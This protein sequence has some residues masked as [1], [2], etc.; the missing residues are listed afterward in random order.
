MPRPKTDQEIQVGWGDLQWKFMNWFNTNTAAID[1]CYWP[2]ADWDAFDQ[3][4]AKDFPQKEHQEAF[5]VWSDE[6]LDRHT[7][8]MTYKMEAKEFIAQVMATNFTNNQ[9][10]SELLKTIALYN[11]PWVPIGT[12]Q[13]E[14]VKSYYAF[15]PS[16]DFLK[17]ERVEHGPDVV[18]KYMLTMKAKPKT[19]A[20]SG[21]TSGL[22]PAS[23]SSNVFN[24]STGST[25]VGESAY[26]RARSST[27]SNASPAKENP[28]KA[29]DK[30]EYFV[31]AQIG[32][33]HVYGADYI[34]AV[35]GNMKRIN[36]GPWWSNGFAVVVELNNKGGHGAVYIVYNHAPLKTKETFPEYAGPSEGDETAFEGAA[37]YHE[38]GKVHPSVK[39]KFKVARIADSIVRLGN[40]QNN[41]QFN[42]PTSNYYTQFS[43]TKIVTDK[44]GK[45]SILHAKDPPKP[46]S[47]AGSPTPKPPLNT[48]SPAQRRPPNTGSPT[49]RQPPPTESPTRRG[50][51][52]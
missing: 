46:P 32:T 28:E 23:P 36:Q 44:N 48:G 29:P 19:S 14:G 40:L 41:F 4:V 35:P 10:V 6:W 12:N 51:G 49:R 16:V 39:T 42:V 47:N 1:R 33:L 20:A 3:L 52:W 26:P 30:D 22:T 11:M 31:F 17:P 2:G 43:T 50:F 13:F 38:P 24:P 15:K 7:Q 8:R 34:P 21:T 9:A 37:A 18:G 27:T 25:S 45:R 5:R